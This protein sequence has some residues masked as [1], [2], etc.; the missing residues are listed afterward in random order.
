MHPCNIKAKQ[1]CYIKI[2]INIR[3]NKL[4]RHKITHFTKMN[5]RKIVYNYIVFYLMIYSLL[6]IR[7]VTNIILFKAHATCYV[8]LHKHRR[9]YISTIMHA[10]LSARCFLRKLQEARERSGKQK[11]ED[12]TSKRGRQAQYTLMAAT[13][14]L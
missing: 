6:S 5:Y 1:F 13:A 11:E 14:T 3:S 7:T 10:G 12:A 9:T 8:T 4:K 2:F